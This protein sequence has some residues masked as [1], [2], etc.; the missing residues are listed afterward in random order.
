MTTLGITATQFGPAGFL[1]EQA[2]LRAELLK[3][4]KLQAIGGFFPVIL[5]DPTKPLQHYRR[6]SE[7][8]SGNS[9]N[10]ARVPPWGSPKHSA[11]L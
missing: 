11:Q 2:A 7:D 5:H 3:Q 9:T 8:A 1:P 4:H 6:D 10:V